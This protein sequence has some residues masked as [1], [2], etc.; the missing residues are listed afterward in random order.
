MDVK[1]ERQRLSQDATTSIKEEIPRNDLQATITNEGTQQ[2]TCN[3]P[4]M[5]KIVASGPNSPSMST[6]Q[7]MKKQHLMPQYSDK[8]IVEQVDESATKLE[9]EKP[10]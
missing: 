1:K 3:H 7:S 5:L 10:E 4:S 2:V 9:E 6:L 8:I